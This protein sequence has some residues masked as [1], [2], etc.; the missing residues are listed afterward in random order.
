MDTARSQNQSLTVRADTADI[1]AAELGGFLNGPKF[2]CPVRG[3]TL[4]V[5]TVPNRTTSL[6]SDSAVRRLRRRYPG[7]IRSVTPWNG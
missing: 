6:A 3:L 5:V 2:F 1:V 4:V 7:A